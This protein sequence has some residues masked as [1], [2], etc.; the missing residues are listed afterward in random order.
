MEVALGYFEDSD[1]EAYDIDTTRPPA[2][3]IEYLKQ[4]QREASLH[5]E[6]VKAPCLTQHSSI[7]PNANNI[8]KK[9][10]PP[11]DYSYIPNEISQSR[12]ASEFADLRQ[13][14]IRYRNKHKS[15]PRDKDE[16]RIPFKKDIDT[17]CQFCFGNNFL[18]PSRE[19]FA[20]EDVSFISSTLRADSVVE[21]GHPP[22]LSL[23]CQIG[24]PLV[25]L[26]LE[27]HMIWL[28]R[29]GFTAEQGRWLYALLMCLDKPTP[30]DALSCVRNISRKLSRLRVKA[31]AEDD[32]EMLF[33]LYYFIIIVSK[34]FSQSDLTLNGNCDF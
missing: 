30:P 17:W 11:K 6:V 15:K 24:Q 18:T 7:Q 27:Y 19:N 1:D 28:N 20:T 31:A 12:A 9:Q 26:L 13:A 5:P 34:Y 10:H 22:L 2:D 4:V 14:F 16:V 21:G 32:T 25:I 33:Q 3:G 23:M 8:P 29:K